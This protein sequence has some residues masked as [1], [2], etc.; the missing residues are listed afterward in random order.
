VI[1]SETTA[2]APILARGIISD[3]IIIMLS[4]KN[5]IDICCYNESRRS[6]R[7]KATPVYQAM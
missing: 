5:K 7:L 4:T 6:S 2:N 3:K 1:D